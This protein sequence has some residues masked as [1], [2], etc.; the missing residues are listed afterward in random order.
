MN[1]PPASWGERLRYWLLLAAVWA[2]IGAF[3]NWALADVF[4]PA[5]RGGLI[6]ALIAIGLH[7][8][9]ANFAGYPFPWRIDSKDRAQWSSE[10]EEF[11]RRA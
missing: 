8:A 2:G 5:V 7:L 6:G 11:L 1:T 4:G 9:K 3:V 10:R